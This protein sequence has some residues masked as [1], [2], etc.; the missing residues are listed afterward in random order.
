MTLFRMRVEPLL[1]LGV[2]RVIEVSGSHTLDALH[3]AI[4][5]AFELDDDHLYAFFMNGHVRDD[6]HGIWRVPRRGEPSAAAGAP[7][8]PAFDLGDE[9]VF[10]VRVEGISESESESESGPAQP[11]I[12]E[13]I[14]EA[15]AQYPDVSGLRRGRGR[16]R[17]LE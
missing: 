11:R 5:H 15:P 9:L 2:V 17:G 7:A 6:E 12:V 3:G 1:A 14:G 16:G 8:E 10:D 4:Q 13:S